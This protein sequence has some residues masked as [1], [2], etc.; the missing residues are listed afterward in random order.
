MGGVFKTA[1]QLEDFLGSQQLETLHCSE[2]ATEGIQC[3]E[4]L[5]AR[6]LRSFPTVG[7]WSSV[8]R[9]ALQWLNGPAFKK[10]TRS[11]QIL[12]LSLSD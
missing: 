1:M 2:V 8:A 7:P 5:S 6:H 9:M 4:E 12:V 10:N 11:K 3:I